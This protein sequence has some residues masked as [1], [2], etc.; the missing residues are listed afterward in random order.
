MANPIDEPDD[1]LASLL[2]D[3]KEIDRRR[4]AAALSD[5]VA[6]DRND[7][8]IRTSPN[9]RRLG[10]RQKVLAVLVARKAV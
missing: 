10:A 9:F 6:I 4:M 2:I 7:G 5:Y 8:R 1:P 3:A